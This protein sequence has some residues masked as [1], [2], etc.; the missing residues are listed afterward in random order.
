MFFGAYLSQNRPIDG[1]LFITSD[2]YNSTVSKIEQK[3]Y[4]SQ[5]ILSPEKGPE[6]AKDELPESI[7]DIPIFE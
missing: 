7:V 6:E 5:P 2:Q 1:K 3:I 4:E